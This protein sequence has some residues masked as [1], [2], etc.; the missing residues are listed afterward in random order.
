YSKAT[1]SACE[2]WQRD[3]V[4]NGVTAIEKGIVVV[5]KDSHE[6]WMKEK[7]DNGWKFGKVKDVVLK[8]H[9]CLVPFEKLSDEQR[10]KDYLFFFITKVLL[11]RAA[12]HLKDMK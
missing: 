7:Y 6:N 11:G 12:V 2:Q 3:T 1:W 10:T 8:I 5:P 4:I 9:P